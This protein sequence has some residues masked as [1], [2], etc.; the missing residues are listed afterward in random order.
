MMAF[1]EQ[2]ARLVDQEATE[3]PEKTEESVQMVTTE[4]LAKMAPLVIKDKLVVTDPLA[5]PVKTDAPASLA[6]VAQACE[7]NLEYAEI[8]VIEAILEVAELAVKMEPRALPAVQVTVARQPM[9]Q[10]ELQEDKAQKV[11]KAH[12]VMMD[13][14]VLQF[15]ANLVTVGLEEPAEL[16]DLRVK[17]AQMHL[18]HLLVC[19]AERETKVD[20]AFPVK[21]AQAELLV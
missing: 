18:A 5:I 17:P 7:E 16:E 4:Y 3:H 10:T 12:L 14:Q 1:P 13:D 11:I 2:K 21:L 19:P 9:E 20:E 8:R 15:L 6:L